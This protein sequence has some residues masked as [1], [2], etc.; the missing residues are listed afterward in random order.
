METTKA[1]HLIGFFICTRQI[2]QQPSITLRAVA[3]ILT[4]DSQCYDHPVMQNI[5]LFRIAVI[6]L[7]LKGIMDEANPIKT[8]QFSRHYKI[9]FTV[10][11]KVESDCSGL[12]LHFFLNLMR[13]FS[14]LFTVTPQTFAIDWVF[15]PMRISFATFISIG[16]IDGSNCTNVLEK[17]G[18]ISSQSARYASSVE[19]FRLLLFEILA[20]S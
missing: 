12:R 20:N 13:W 5:T 19:I 17:A 3:S 9:Y 14:I 1:N 10:A 4:P 16:V 18:Y 11:I 15:K 6:T 2:W 7:Q 8:L